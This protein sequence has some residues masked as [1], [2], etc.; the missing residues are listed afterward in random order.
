MRPSSE[1]MSFKMM[2][3]D[4][5]MSVLA[6]LGAAEGHQAPLI[7]LRS[8]AVRDFWEYGCSTE[9]GVPYVPLRVAVE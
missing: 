1:C 8:A 7:A 9:T 5:L 3:R 2:L 4:P 6:R